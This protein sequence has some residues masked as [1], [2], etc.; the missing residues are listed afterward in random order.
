[1]RIH[2]RLL[3]WG[4]IVLAP[5][6]AIVWIAPLPPI[7]I[8]PVSGQDKSKPKKPA[9]GSRGKAPGNTKAL[10]IQADQVQATYTKEA[11]ELAGKYFDAG[12]PEK[13]RALLESVLAVNPDAPNIQQKLE[14]VK[15]GVLA[16]NEFEVEVN[17]SQGWKPTPALVEEKHSI[18]IK[19]EGTYRF[20]MGVGG[21]TAAGFPEREPAEDMIPGIPCGALVG[22]IIGEG[23]TGKPFLIGE[24]LENFAPRESGLLYLRINAPVGNKNS[25]KIKVTISGNVQSSK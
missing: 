3:L 22:I 25:G 15:E 17:P 11:E 23:K 24:K 19:A 10:D 6:L 7:P 4:P 20:E 2:H 8:S 16:S 13:A 18:R 1:M 12:Q 9:K 21:V 5:L 14:R